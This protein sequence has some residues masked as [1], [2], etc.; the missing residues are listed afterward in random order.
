[1][2]LLRKIHPLDAKYANKNKWLALQLANLDMDE[3]VG[4]L[5]GL[6]R[7]TAERDGCGI[8]LLERE[9]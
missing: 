7:S 1:L 8:P 6:N 3:L 9:V 2:C 4:I 5:P